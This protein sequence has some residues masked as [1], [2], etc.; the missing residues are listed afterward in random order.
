MSL[1]LRSVK[2]SRLSLLR[3]FEKADLGGRP[4]LGNDYFTNS[5][6]SIVILRS[7]RFKIMQ[8]TAGT[9]TVWCCEKSSGRWT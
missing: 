3:A 1:W 8:A 9:S 4:M 5:W 7:I 2:A 6:T